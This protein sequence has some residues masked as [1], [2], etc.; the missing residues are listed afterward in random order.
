MDS[1]LERANELKQALTDFVLD[2]EGDLAT[3]LETYTAEQLARSQQKDRKQQ[4]LAVDA[5]LSAGQVGDKTPLD[6]FI[7]SESGLSEHDRQLLSDWKRAFTGLFAIQQILPDGFE[8]MNWL[9]TKTYIVKPNN[10]ATLEEM[11]RLKVGEILLTR[12]APVDDYWTF[13]SPHIQMGNLGKPKLAVAIGNF[14]QNHKSD[15]YGDAPELLEEAW[16]SVDRYH[17]DFLDFFG[18]DEMTLPG[19]QLSKKIPEFQEFLT[20]RRLDEAGI[21]GSKSLSEMAQ[22]AGMSDEELGDVAEAMGMDAQTATKM[23]E[24]KDAVKMA[25]PQIDIPSDLKKA[26]QVTVLAH[27][28]WGQMFLTTHTQFINLL[29]TDDWQNVKGADKLIRNYLEAP[30][31]N[32]FVWH[33]LAQQYPVQ[34]EKVL[35]GFLQRPEFD[36]K[37]DLDSLLRSHHK[38]LEPELP[39]IAS[40]PI[41]LHDLF[42]EA[43]AE[44]TKSQ[45][46]KSEK[47]GTKGFQRA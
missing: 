32:A 37:A 10:S 39:E 47:K 9:T 40:V 6:L 42:Q 46:K 19:Y 41:H 5:F 23:L 36:L 7:E 35:Q 15:L 38:P 12:I 1:I 45:P 25:A 29:Q 33:R 18:S 20:Q 24:N 13:F 4:D 34:L 3:A 22:D 8:L 27:P 2:A 26:E 30:E 14:K 44:V 31:I 16:K 21:D 28:R 43:L 11:A 17:Q